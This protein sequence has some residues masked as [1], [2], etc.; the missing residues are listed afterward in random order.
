MIVFVIP[1]QSPGASRNWA[2]VS[3]LAIRTVRS[4]L[5]QTSSRFRVILV[6]NERPAGLPE[7][8]NLQVLEVDLPV[9]E[10]NTDDRMRDKGRKIQRALVSVRDLAPFHY[11]AVDAD[12]CVHRGLAEFVSRNLQAHGW[13]LQKGYVHDQGTP[14]LI[15]KNDFHLFCGT[16]HIVRVEQDDLP[17]LADEPEEDWW[18]LRNGISTMVTF[19]A[20]R[21]TPLEVLPFIGAVYNTDTGEND[22]GMALSRWRSRKVTLIKLINTVWLSPGIRKTYGLYELPPAP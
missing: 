15:R 6:C 20:E 8:P 4:A 19:L 16:S 9:P 21:G 18:V 12:D 10:R 13:Y 17:L 22:S 2:R 1:L 7:H 5:A 11:M 14:W 3:A